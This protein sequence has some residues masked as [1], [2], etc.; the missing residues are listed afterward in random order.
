VLFDNEDT[1]GIPVQRRRIGF[2]AR[3]IV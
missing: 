1:T 3:Q 2:I